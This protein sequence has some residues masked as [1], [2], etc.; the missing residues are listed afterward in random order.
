[1]GAQLL[2][3]RAIVLLAPPP[4]H[5][6]GARSREACRETK[7]D[8]GVGAGDQRHFSC[9]IKNIVFHERYQIVRIWARGRRSRSAAWRAAADTIGVSEGNRLRTSAMLTLRMV[10]KGRSSQSSQRPCTAPLG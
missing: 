2:L 8:A 9:Q 1:M 3:G 7:T 5:D 6:V 10:G 4:D